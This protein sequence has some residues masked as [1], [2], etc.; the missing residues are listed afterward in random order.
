[1]WHGPTFRLTIR[2][3]WLKHGQWT[4]GVSAAVGCTIGRM[5]ML[6]QQLRRV[7]P[8]RR[9]HDDLRTGYFVPREL[10]EA[11]FWKGCCQRQRGGR[12]DHGGFR[13]G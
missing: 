3:A 6:G 10:G 4:N 5:V 8:R 1:M 9:L 11:P 12:A 7:P 2:R 13:T